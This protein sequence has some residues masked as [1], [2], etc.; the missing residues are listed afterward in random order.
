MPQILIRFDDI[1]PAMNWDRWSEIEYTLDEAGVK[2]ILAVVPDNR[3]PTLEFGSV[4]EDFWPVVRGWQS[5]RWAIAMH[6][7]QHLYKTKRGGILR[8][9]SRSE[10]AGLPAAEQRQQLKSG[11]EIF[12]REGVEPDAW[13]APAHSFDWTTVDLLGDLGIGVISDGL[14]RYPH[15]DPR[16]ILW[17]PQQLWRFRAVPAGVW[18]VCFHHNDWTARDLN[19]FRTDL[20]RYRE[21]VTT[22]AEV[23]SKYAGRRKTMSDRFV[24]AGMRAYIQGAHCYG[25][26]R[27]ALAR[28]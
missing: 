28:T 24:A 22:L 19:R 7:Y 10:F 5:R 11:I 4:R 18:T 15:R 6:G 20:S 3:D 25:A 2:P 12:R 17:V 26:L 27:R 21:H 14:H 23:C 9:N 8:L 1:C 13:I 16:G